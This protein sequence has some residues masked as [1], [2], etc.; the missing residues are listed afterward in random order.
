[1]KKKIV[2]KNSPKIELKPVISF[3]A[4]ELF[5]R[6][7][8]YFVVVLM[9]AGFV[10]RIHRLDFLSL[11]SDEFIIPDQAAGVFQGKSILSNHDNNGIFLTV[12]V[13]LS[14]KLFGIS[15]FSARIISVILGTLV[16]PATYFL[17]KI[18]FNRFV[19]LMSAVLATISVYSV[20]WSRVSRNY[21]CFEL[22]YLLLIIVFWFM[23]EGNTAGST[24]SWFDRHKIHK[25]Y[26]ILF[27]VALLVSLLNHQ[28][29]FFFIFTFMSYGSGIAVWKIYKKQEGRFTNK[30]SWVLYG[31]ML[32]MFLFYTPFMADII[33]P[34]VGLVM[35]EEG[36]LWFIPRWNIIFGMWASPDPF[37]VFH[38]YTSVLK[39]DFT[40][41]WWLGFI[42]LI[43]AFFVNRKS[44]VF[45]VALFMIPLL[46]MSFVFYDPA[47]TR[48][49]IF[50]YPFFLIGVGVAVYELWHLI[51]RYFIPST[52]AMRP[53]FSLTM[54]LSSAV[55]LVA[56]SPVKELSALINPQR[57]GMV[58][59]PEISNW[60]F[61]NWR[62]AAQH[63]K[64]QIQKDDVVFSTMPSGTNH[65]LGI[66]SS[67]WFRQMHYS[68]YVKRYISNEKIETTLPNGTTYD[69]F[70]ETVQRYKRGWVFADYYFYNVMTDPRV[71]DYVVRNLK[72]HFDACSDGTVQVFSWDQNA[73][74][75]PKS[76]VFELGKTP[77]MQASQQ[78][79]I[80]LT[81][82]AGK[83]KV[84]MFVDAEAINDD[85]EA[86][87]VI[88]NAHSAFI[89]RCKSDQREVVVAEM[90]I[91]WFHDG[92]N[93]VQF[94]YNPNTIDTRKGFAIY[95]VSF[96]AE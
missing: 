91:A 40:N 88:N 93:I 1:M 84:R 36:V 27:P 74:E 51:G 69:N 83:S 25:K 24:A 15:D 67:L 57:H 42:G 48:Y 2:K 29:T 86:F 20:F 28:L 75:P 47:T 49:M 63:V 43:A 73:P 87:V 66:D 81:G 12:L 30:Y 53:I 37:K 59:R 34:V 61:S 7:A 9:I 14:Y 52:F 41:F 5:E 60:F 38:I 11:W 76:F 68:E 62:E 58:A 21:A 22:F 46:L 56:A 33:R 16:I 13:F 31:T 85:K 55:F 39:A 79:P 89:P 17:G 19:G 54:V 4:S 77:E 6:Y 35:H 90:N 18:L 72:Y 44:A 82:L 64:P 10:I 8:I 96:S 80:D 32:F 26:L 92:Q 78:F 71:R 3:P 94:A 50:I 23:I 70:I 95:N 65:Y 45:L